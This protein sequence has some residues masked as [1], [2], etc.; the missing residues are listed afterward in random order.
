MVRRLKMR[1]GEVR[2]G[3]LQAVGSVFPSLESLEIMYAGVAEELGD[4]EA[5]V[6][7]ILA[8]ASVGSATLPNLRKLDIN[9]SW[10][11]FTSLNAVSIVPWELI[12]DLNLSLRYGFGLIPALFGGAARWPNLMV[13]KLSGG[14]SRLEYLESLFDSYI[15]RLEVIELSSTDVQYHS[16]D[17]LRRCAQWQN[18]REVRFHSIFRSSD[19][20]LAFAETGLPRLEAMELSAGQGKGIFSVLGANAHRWPL[21]R[22]LKCYDKPTEQE[23]VAF[24]GNK[25]WNLS[26]LHL[27]G[28]GDVL[29]QLGALPEAAPLRASLRVFHHLEDR[30][31]CSLSSALFENCWIAFEEL[32][33]IGL[34]INV[35]AAVA[36][37]A[38]VQQ[39]RLPR[40]R[41]LDLKGCIIYD[42]ALEVLCATPFKGLEE[43]NLFK[44]ELRGDGWSV[45]TQS[46][47]SF[48]DICTLTIK[49]PSV[50]RM[51]QILC[52][53]WPPSLEKVHLQCDDHWG[54]VEGYG[55]GDWAAANVEALDWEAVIIE[56]VQ[57]NLE[58]VD[59]LRRKY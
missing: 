56:R 57:D 5:S 25:S 51:K 16:G 32:H 3:T 31:K 53:P 47:S 22:T 37:S 41:K 34:Q 2:P 48:P 44:A 26:C 10:L 17:V 43:L 27:R 40:L 14:H 52:A 58:Y 7:L 8:L 36:L 13:L 59:Y 9:R 42:D 11:S 12:E 24:C 1:A 19:D 15:P 20:L 55:L 30:T 23:I 6:R 39:G 21:L 35:A 38:A 28:P 46:A 33:F 49:F 54:V 45:L 18:L 29:G 4:V 50:H